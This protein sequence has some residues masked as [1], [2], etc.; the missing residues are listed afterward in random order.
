MRQEED[1]LASRSSDLIDYLRHL[2]PRTRTLATAAFRK[3]NLLEGTV[4]GG[5][6][7]SPDRGCQGFPPTLRP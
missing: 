5:P 4:R 6:F 3:A 2:Q 7:P 1:T